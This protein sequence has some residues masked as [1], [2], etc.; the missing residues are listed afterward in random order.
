MNDKEYLEF[1]KKWDLKSVSIEY[2]PYSS[3][4]DK[5]FV[6]CCLTRHYFKSNPVMFLA[7]STEESLKRTTE[8]LDKVKKLEE[9]ATIPIPILE[10]QPYNCGY[11]REI[12]FQDYEVEFKNK[13]GIFYITAI[14][15][16]DLNGFYYTDP[17][18]PVKDEYKFIKHSDEGDVY[19]WNDLGFL[20]GSKGLLIVKDGMVI[21]EKMTAI[22]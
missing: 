14:R 13:N 15:R 8:L 18:F 7:S 5:M 17:P 16:K 21:K 10:K 2:E 1:V 9:I 20:S 6:V 11:Y 22:S 4:S 3:F 19:E 12:V